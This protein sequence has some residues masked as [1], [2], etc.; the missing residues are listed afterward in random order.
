MST[1][2]PLGPPGARCAVAAIMALGLL[3][4]AGCDS[5]AATREGR[6]SATK[7][8]PPPGLEYEPP[9]PGTYELPPI[10]PAVDG[11]VLAADGTEHRLFDYLG[12]RYVL[13]SFIYTRCTDRRGCPFATATF[14]LVEE[15]LEQEPEVAE[16][17]RLITLSFDPERDTAEVM[18]GYGG[19][20]ESDEGAEENDWVFLTTASQAELQPILDGYGQY[21]V[22]ETDEEGRFLGTF[23]HVLKVYLI[24]REGRV[25]NIYSTSFL[26]HEQVLN[27][28]KT[29]ILQQERAGR[30]RRASRISSRS[31]IA[32]G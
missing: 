13:L 7:A 28:L 20:V 30:G 14:Q 1:V 21:I 22:P 17:V 25:R 32:R 12:D 4:V 24:D 6:A 23:T 19:A 5:Q 29:L 31:P 26:H 9:A 16:Q 8:S 18:D 3:L 15:R 27:D 11:D 2:A 10:Q